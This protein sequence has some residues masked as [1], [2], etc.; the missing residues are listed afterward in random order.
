VLKLRDARTGELAQALPAGRRQ[1]RIL[2]AAPGHLRAYLTADLLRRAAEVA[3]LLPTVTELL[4]ASATAGILHAASGALNIYPPQD[5]LTAPVDP[6]VGIPLFDVG[7]RPANMAMS[8]DGTDRARLWVDVGSDNQEADLGNEPLA[9]RLALMRHGH[10]EAVQGG[11]EPGSAGEASA[12]EAAAVL[13]RWRAL[14]AQW[15]RSP[16]AAMSREYGEAITHA[17]ANDLDTATALRA[18]TKLT[19]DPD[20][21]DGVKFETFAAADRL[22]GLDLTRDIGK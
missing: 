13:A 14:V 20:L 8:S 21:P 1:L 2:V 9:V 3:G 17:F 18:L 4:P 12:S 6:L 22:L 15:A 11:G 19:D 16:S 5:I 10:A 7:I